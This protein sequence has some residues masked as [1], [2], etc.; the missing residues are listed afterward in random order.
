MFL[1]IRMSTETERRVGNLLDGSQ[2]AGPANDSS[3]A[4]GQGGK[5]SSLGVKIVKPVSILETDAA[6]E[7]LS[8]E[9]KQR[10]DK[11]KVTIVNLLVLGYYHILYL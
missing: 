4:S 1:Q 2:K 3:A 6:K 10:Q 8:L 11:L 7:R 9:L 5:Q